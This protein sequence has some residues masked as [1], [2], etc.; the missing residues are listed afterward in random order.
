MESTCWGTSATLLQRVRNEEDGLG[1][2]CVA[3]TLLW[4]TA[5]FAR[6]GLNETDVEDVVQEVFQKVAT[7]LGS[8]RYERP[9]GSFRGW[10]WTISRNKIRD[11]FRNRGSRPPHA[12]RGSRAQRMLHD[13]PDWV[14]DENNSGEPT[15]DPASEAALMRR[16]L[17]LIS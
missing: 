15:S 8:F 16:A 1:S 11:W 6:T 12:T 13:I 14:S 4:C 2:S 9:G 5:G 3:S 17:E 10:L 7:K